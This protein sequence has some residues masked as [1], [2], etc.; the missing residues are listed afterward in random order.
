[1]R[2]SLFLYSPKV[3][4]TIYNPNPVPI[5][6]PFLSTLEDSNAS[7]MRDGLSFYFLSNP[8]PV[9]KNLIDIVSSIIVPEIFISRLSIP[10]FSLIA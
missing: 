10:F 8:F 9:S 4:F 3:D 1:M 2:I 6:T 5:L 7:K